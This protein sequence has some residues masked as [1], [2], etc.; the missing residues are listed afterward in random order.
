MRFAFF[1]VFLLS[2]VFALAQEVSI[3]KSWK[4]DVRKFREK[5]EWEYMHE[6]RTPLT[7]E[8]KAHF[9]GLDYFRADRDFIVIARFIRTPDAIPF[10]MM[11][12]SGKTR[13]YVK[14]ADLDFTVQGRTLKLAVYQNIQLVKDEKYKNHLFLPFTDFTCGIESYGGG[15][16]IDLEIPAGQN[17]LIDFNQCYNPYC[18]YST[19]WNCPIVPDENRLDIRIVAGVKKWHE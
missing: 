2:T 12:S 15:R 7:P 16:Y 6:E 8:D 3:P 9:K 18:A 10:A 17:I 19:G 13:E 1:F 5:L 14:Y 11:T 4:K